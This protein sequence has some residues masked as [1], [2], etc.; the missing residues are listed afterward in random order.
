MSAKLTQNRQ[1][2]EIES[3]LLCSYTRANAAAIWILRQSLTLQYYVKQESSSLYFKLCKK[4]PNVTKEVL[5]IVASLKVAYS[6]Q[7]TYKKAHRKNSNFTSD[8]ILLVD[9]FE[10]N[11][12]LKKRRVSIKR[13]TILNKLSLILQWRKLNISWINIST[14]VLTIDGESISPEYI[15]KTVDSLK[16]ISCSNV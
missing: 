5:S 11:S 15:R 7:M 9:I 2:K 4:H 3:L 10:S 12:F 16:E 13:E 1:E 6:I 8:D 14:R